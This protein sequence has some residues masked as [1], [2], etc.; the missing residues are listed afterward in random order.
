MK[1][2]IA[3]AWKLYG[4]DGYRQEESFSKSYKIDLSNDNQ[5]R[6]YEVFNSDRIHTNMFS[7]VKITTN[8]VE[9]CCKELDAQISDGLFK[10]IEIGKVEEI[11]LEELDKLIVDGS[12]SW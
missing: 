8:S 9:D 3:K 6:V 4:L 10:N 2:I 1:K 11:T 5:T 7:V 12:K